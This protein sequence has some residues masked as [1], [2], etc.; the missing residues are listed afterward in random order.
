MSKQLMEDYFEALLASPREEA[1]P[2]MD[3]E[4]SA[5]ER[6]REKVAR[7]LAQVNA[8]V[9][10]TPRPREAE[11]PV[12]TAAPEVVV[13]EPVLE[14]AQTAPAEPAISFEDKAERRGE[15]QVLLFDVAGLELAVPLDE[16]GGIHQLGEINSL[17]GKPAWFKGIMVQRQQQLRVV[18]TGLWVMPDKQQQEEYRYLVMLGDS[19]WG[20]ACNSLVRTEVLTG[21]QVRW[22]SPGSKRPWLA[23]MVK[24]RMCALLDVSAM[25]GMLEQGAG[26]TEH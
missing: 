24:S 18:D 11:A 7:L 2:V 16:L 6:E 15:F 9:A 26:A 8:K 12:E 13:P 10:E 14:V 1:R 23:G 17:F 5:A 25:L 3:A 21:E 19:P 4:P 20:L 22:R